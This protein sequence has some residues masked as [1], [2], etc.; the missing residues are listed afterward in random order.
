M[1]ALLFLLIPIGMAATAIIFGYGMYTF[2][3]GDKETDDP[4]EY[5]ERSNKIMRM[6]VT[7]QAVTIVIALIFAA[8]VMG[9]Q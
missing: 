7:A 5:A 9:S 2:M 1:K 3:N 8:L 4:K 6:R